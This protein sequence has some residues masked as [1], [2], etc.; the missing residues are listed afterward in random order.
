MNQ[1]QTTPHVTDSD[2]NINLCVTTGVQTSDKTR[3][4]ILLNAPDN[5][6]HHVFCFEVLIRMFHILLLLL[7]IS[8]T[9]LRNFPI[10]RIKNE[11]KYLQKIVN[12]QYA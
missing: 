6:E 9:K 12:E 10:I 2:L 1:H 4:T 3:L 11:E 7:K 5:I 8:T